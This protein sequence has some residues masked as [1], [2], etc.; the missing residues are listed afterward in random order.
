M[1]SSFITKH[2][3]IKIRKEDAD[4]FYNPSVEYIISD[5]NPNLG[6]TYYTQ[7]HGWAI[8]DYTLYKTEDGKTEYNVITEF[9]DGSKLLNED[10]SIKKDFLNFGIDHLPILVTAE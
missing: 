5:D 9:K 7:T 1:Q 10:I 6:G 3:K 4:V 2:N 8:L